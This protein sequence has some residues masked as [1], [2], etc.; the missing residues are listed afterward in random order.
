MSNF[1]V[2]RAYSKQNQLIYVGRS[3]NFHNRI[4]S[5]KGFSEWFKKVDFFKITHFETDSEMRL[6]EKAIIELEKPLFNIQYTNKEPNLERKKRKANIA[7]GLKGM[8]L[9]KFKGTPPEI[10]EALKVLRVNAV[11]AGTGLHRNTVM[12]IRDGKIGMSEKTQG[13]LSAFIQGTRTTPAE[14]TRP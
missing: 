11:C 3:V 13:A 8:E 4:S 14:S 5:H 1:C 10:R 2:Y 6:Y 7:E 12:G 9:G